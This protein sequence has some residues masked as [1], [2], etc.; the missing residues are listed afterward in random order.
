VVFSGSWLLAA[1]FRGVVGM[2]AGLAWTVAGS[3]AGSAGAVFAGVQVWQATRG[4]DR[5]PAPVLSAD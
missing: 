5:A 3:V 2:D 4:A 1:G